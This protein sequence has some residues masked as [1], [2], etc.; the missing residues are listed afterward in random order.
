M[1]RLRE[2]EK[3]SSDGNLNITRP[4]LDHRIGSGGC[5]DGQTDRRTG[6]YRRIDATIDIAS[7]LS[8]DDREM[9]KNATFGNVLF[10]RYILMV[11]FVSA[12][13]R[14]F[15]PRRSREMRELK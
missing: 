1:S 5:T 3:V 8:T 2:R 13:V 14:D 10:T 9:Q 7:A 11:E 12:R 15:T 6:F 4:L